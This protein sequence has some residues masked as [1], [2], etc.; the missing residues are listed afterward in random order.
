MGF[1]FGMMK[2]SGLSG[3]RSPP[4]VRLI[5]QSRSRTQRNIPPTRV[6]VYY[7][8]T[9]LKKQ[10][11]EEMRRAKSGTRRGAST[12]SPGCHSPQP[13]TRSPTGKLSEACPLGFYAS[14]PPVIQPPAPLPKSG[15]E[16]GA[17][18]SSNLLITGL[19]KRHFFFII[20]SCVGTHRRLCAAG[21]TSL[22]ELSRSRLLGPDSQI[23]GPGTRKQ[24][25]VPP[26]C[27]HTEGA[28]GS[29]A[30][31]CASARNRL[32]AKLSLAQLAAIACR[33]A[34]WVM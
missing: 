1:L 12:R 8:R 11:D 18:E 4:Q 23:H 16:V 20:L 34:F 31:T 32:H 27:H 2:C 5:C 28:A 13:S 30:P 19:S 33:G 24:T 6:P 7:K 15:S 9:E 14:L 3:D 10:L 29:T 17:T 26:N 21:R 22:L 25:K